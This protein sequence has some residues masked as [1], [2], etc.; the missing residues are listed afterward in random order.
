MDSCE[1]NIILV[2]YSGQNMCSISTP[3]MN[4][5]WTLSL[6]YIVVK[7]CS[8]STPWMHERWTLSLYYIVVKTCSISTPWIHERWTLS[9]YYIAVK[10]C[11]A[12]AHHGCM[13]G[14][15][16]D[17]EVVFI[18]F[19]FLQ[20]PNWRGITTFHATSWRISRTKTFSL[21]FTIWNTIS[22]SGIPAIHTNP[23]Y[24]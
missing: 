4:E 10:T 23:W 8:I 11:V 12:S 2:L 17:P 20:F 16:P 18:L 13:W 5:R 15:A 6:Y 9:L 3:W 14:T 21:D 22:F 19:Y 1:V 7:T 24:L